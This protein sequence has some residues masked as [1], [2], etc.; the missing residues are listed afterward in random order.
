MPKVHELCASGC[1]ILQQVRASHSDWLWFYCNG[2]IEYFSPDYKT[3]A[4]EHRL[5]A[6]RA[7]GTTLDRRTHIHHINEQKDDNRYANLQVISNERHASIH[8][9]Q[10]AKVF[11]CDVCGKVIKRRSSHFKRH[12]SHYCS[13]VCKAL[14]T[15]KVA[16]RPTKTEL[17]RLIET[18]ANFK[19]IGRMYKVSDNAIRYWAK[20][21]GLTTQRQK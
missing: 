2:Y 9:G 14:G 12:T 16:V 17:A 18:V 20:G 6:E 7:L 5:V 15:R 11:H 19:E 10:N 21:Y 8:H 1:E 4:Y 3:R 13:R